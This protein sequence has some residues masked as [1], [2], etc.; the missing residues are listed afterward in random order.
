MSEI[1]NLQA[2][3]DG[4][5][6]YFTEKKKYI[7]SFKK[8]ILMTIHSMTETLKRKLSFEQETMMN[9]SDMMIQLYVAESTLLR[10]EK[11][12]SIK[13]ADAIELQKDILDVVIYDAATRINKFGKDAIYAFAEDDSEK[14][15]NAL[16]HFTNVKGVNSKAARR[17]VAAHLIE[18]NKY[19]F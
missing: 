3:L 13:G 18:E 16:N 1:D 15:I 19:K 11:L 8:A 12:E 2:T 9:V 6:D 14:L 7:K 4:T 5:E 10:V 17:R